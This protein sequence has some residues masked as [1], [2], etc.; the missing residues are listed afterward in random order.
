MNL[1]GEERRPRVTLRVH[2]GGSVPP[3]SPPSPRKAGS[4]RAG[5]GRGGE[6]PSQGHSHSEIRPAGEGRKVVFH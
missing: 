4:R 2:V 6:G 3:G 5:A 1:Q